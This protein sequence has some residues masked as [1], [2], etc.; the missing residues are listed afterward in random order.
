MP[1]KKKAPETQNDPPVNAAPQ[2]RYVGPDYPRV[3]LLPDGPEFVPS[4]ITQERIITLMA[5]D[6]ER[7]ARY[8]ALNDRVKP[9]IEVAAEAP[10]EE[11]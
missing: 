1:R 3:K 4:T 2:W 10:P 6:P 5:R 7:M 8:F 11:E 9:G